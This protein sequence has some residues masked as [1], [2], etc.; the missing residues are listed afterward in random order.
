MLKNLKRL[1]ILFNLGEYSESNNGDFYVCFVRKVL[2]IRKLY[3]FC[4]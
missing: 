1:M 4:F 3:L 2:C